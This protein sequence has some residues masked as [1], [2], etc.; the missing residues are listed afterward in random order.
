[1]KKGDYLWGF[2]LMIWVAILVIPAS[3]TAFISATEAHPYI[4]GFIKFFILATMGDLLGIRVLKGEWLIPK[5]L[6]YRA[7][8]WGIIGLMVTLVF[9]VYMGG[10]AAAQASGKLPFK[11]SDIAQAFFGSA[12]MNVTFGPMMMAFHR[13]TDMYIDAG[14]ENN[15]GKVTI[16]KLV[17]K[18]DWHSLVEFSWLKTCPYFW[19]PAHTIV[20]LLPGQ[21]RVLVSAFLSVALGLLLAIAKK[22]K[23]VKAGA[24]A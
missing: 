7:I 11:G 13:F 10:A 21:Y 12:I 22:G 17:D 15:R 19:I 1:M 23:S 24:A 8:I 18:I 20:F 9:T 4:G 16:S 14:Y 3:R 2:A 6:F 5:G